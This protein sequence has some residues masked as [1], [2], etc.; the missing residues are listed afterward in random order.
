MKFIDSIT[1]D[2]VIQSAYFFSILFTMSICSYSLF[3]QQLEMQAFKNDALEE[4][5]RRMAQE[6]SFKLLQVMF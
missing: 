2:Y 6:E 5:E 3:I 1:E 4:R